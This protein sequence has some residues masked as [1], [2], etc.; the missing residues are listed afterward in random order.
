MGAAL[1]G[2]TMRQSNLHRS[3]AAALALLLIATPGQARRLVEIDG[4]ELRG[5]AQVVMYGA[6]T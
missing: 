1:G 2:L 3:I 5:T 4:I 6:A